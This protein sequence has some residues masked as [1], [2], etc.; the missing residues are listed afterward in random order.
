MKFLDE[1]KIF[2]KAGDGGNGCVAFRREKYIEFGGPA[3]GNG[4]R[5][6]D[7]LVEAVEALNTLIDYRYR[8]HC[9]AKRGTDGGGRDRAGAHG[10]DLVLRVPVGTQIFT[11]D[12]ERLITDL[13][14][15]GERR[16]VARGG[17]GGRGNTAFKSST[18]RTPRESES[19]GDGEALC[20]WLKLKLIADAG[21][22]G[23]PNA[24]KSTLLG[25]SSRARPKIADYP[26][27]TLH[28]ALGVVALD[29]EEFVLADVP[30]LI[31]GAHTGRGLGCK[32]LGHV[33][34]CGV[35]LHVIDVIQEDPV[36]AYNQVREELLAYGSVLSGKKEIV[37]LN[38]CDA[39]SSELV[40]EKH[41]DLSTHVSSPV[42]AIS[43]VTG[44]GITHVLRAVLGAVKLNRK[45]MDSSVGV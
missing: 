14:K 19:G 3:G 15:V 27:T 16:L 9:A 25:A 23:L 10:A 7:V 34:R 21:L 33:E 45:D 41:R 30:G 36:K 44:M 39:I 12:G 1:T 20:L 42:F 28:P 8:Q 31:E 13:E 4:G 24:G 18:N 6:G 17:H 38:K 11:E 2:V 43:A 35:L 37:V 40:A 29:D 22:V 32:F 5:G 26:F